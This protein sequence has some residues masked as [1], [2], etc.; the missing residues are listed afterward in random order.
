MDRLRQGLER[1]LEWIVV[2]LMASLALLVVV[3]VIFRKTGGALVW[4]DEVAS[5]MLAW[6]TYYGAALAALNH[7]HIGFPRFVES[8]RAPVRRALI[9]V[10][11]TIVVAFF[12]VVT[13]AGI[14]VMQILGGLTLTS[15][16]WVPARV[17]QSVIPVGAVLFIVAEVL[18][19]TQRL[20]EPASP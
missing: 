18:S 5:V 11:S 16:P 3:A 12:L 9:L 13:W 8:A 17:T 6:L 19:A 14:R 10:R 20:R 4:Y 2:G 15:L 7:Q 1:S